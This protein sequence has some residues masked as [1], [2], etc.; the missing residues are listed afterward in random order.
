ML[1]A[2]FHITK[3]NLPIVVIMFGEIRISNLKLDSYRSVNCMDALD[4][5]S[6]L[7]NKK[8]PELLK[9]IQKLEV[10][11]N[12]YSIIPTK[13]GSFSLKYSIKNESKLLHSSYN[14]IRE[15]QQ[16]IDKY[17]FPGC[18]NYIVIGMGFG[19]HINELMSRAPEAMI[20][21]IEMNLEIYKLAM[22]SIDLTEIINNDKVIIHPVYHPEEIGK[23][24]SELSAQQNMKIIIHEPSLSAL[25][26]K[27]LKV[28]MLLE[29]FVLK[30][31]TI[32]IYTEQMELNFYENIKRYDK[33]V[34][35]LFNKHKNLPIFI[36]AA[37]P[38]LD[39]N[40]KTLQKIGDKGVILSVGRAIKPLLE[41]EVNINYVIV[42]EPS[43][44]LYGMQ[45]E[46]VKL[47]CPIIVLSTCDQNVIRNYKGTSYIAFQKG[48]RLAEDYAI[49]NHCTTI[50]TGGSV[51]TTALDIAIRMGGNPIVFVGQDLAFTDN[52]THASYTY[53]QKVMT[54]NKLRTI[55]D[56]NGESVQTSI[57]LNIFLRWIQNRIA[58]EN[59]ITFIDGTEG[60]A[61][62][63][64]TK[65][66]TLEQVIKEYIY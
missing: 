54:T 46:G 11:S 56:I 64:G 47:I 5:N 3:G 44:R 39:K 52:K 27:Y 16:M 63:E 13:N 2:L 55:K 20:H 57:S 38:S 49:T 31:N 8:N 21:I 28:K 42:S 37:G 7:L 48:F 33:K 41:A 6:C 15:A 4:M 25:K 1:L 30:Y 59:G 22:A 50:E 23:I 65:V 36:V 12:I 45:L 18:E 32:D 10:D 51:A 14:P 24:L 9:Y 40:I 58:E 19:Y 26:P 66:M 53:S 29:E 43:P 35:D 17:Y 34:D 62:I 60:G 61:M